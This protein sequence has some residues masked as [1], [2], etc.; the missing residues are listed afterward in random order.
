MRGEFIILGLL[1]ILV[2][3]ILQMKAKYQSER[4]RTVGLVLLGIVLVAAGLIF[5]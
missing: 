5:N 2:A 4:I 3:L 1:V